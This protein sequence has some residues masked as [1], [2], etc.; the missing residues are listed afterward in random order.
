MKYGASADLTTMYDAVHGLISLTEVSVPHS[1]SDL[2]MLLNSSPMRR[3]RRIKLLGYAGHRYVAADYSRYAH[4]IGTFHIMSR[5]IHQLDSRTEFIERICTEVNKELHLRRK[6]QAKDLRKHLLMA[7]LLQDV[8]ELPFSQVT[9][10]F[11]RPEAQVL[12]MIEG[13]LG[14]TSASWTTKQIFTFA[15]AI[16]AKVLSNFD[17]NAVLLAYLITG[18]IPWLDNSSP[19]R[20]LY[21]MVDGHVDADR[22]DY[23]HRDLHHT[24]GWHGNAEAVIASLVGYDKAGPIFD[25]PGP[26]TQFLFSRAYLWSNVYFAPPNRFRNVLLANILREAVRVPKLRKLFCLES[27]GISLQQFLELD[28]EKLTAILEQCRNLAEFSRG[29]SR[30]A[31]DLLLEGTTNYECRWIP[32]PP[33]NNNKTSV[34]VPPDLFHD[35]YSDYQEHSLFTTG[36]IQIESARFGR[37][38]SR[39]FLEECSSPFR[40]LGDKH[41]S[42]LESQN[43]VLLYLP[44]TRQTPA[45]Q[46]FEP[47]IASYSAYCRYWEN[48]PFSR[49]EF[50]S[51]TTQFKLFTGKPIFLSFSFDDIA[52]VNKILDV[53][54]SYRRRYYLLAGPFDGYLHTTDSNSR[55]AARRA[56]CAIVLA[57][58]AYLEMLNKKDSNIAAEFEVLGARKHKDRKFRVAVVKTD[59]QERL[60]DFPF[61]KLGMRKNSYIGRSLRLSGFDQIEAAMKIVLR[62]LDDK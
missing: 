20:S 60:R 22:L 34:V 18:K 33:G 4:A 41:W 32:M 43:S 12:S 29:R 7:A 40:E 25:D 23:V 62:Y 17:L 57:S 46:T 59:S 61:S 14:F 39:H 26:I 47:K 53:L 49:V 38:S 16:D 9:K 3:L 42:G 37:R 8:G 2:L 55:N 21:Q 19:L 27:D 5:L 28:E 48:D 11:Y 52:V 44:T 6:I 24:V 1:Q 58:A 51:D 56:G 13:V 35:G 45:W 10:R 36:T 50:P 31:L 54:Y 15:A 30:T